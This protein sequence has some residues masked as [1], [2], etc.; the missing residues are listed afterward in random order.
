MI[1]DAGL[2]GRYDTGRRLSPADIGTWMA[3]ARPFLPGPGGAVL[4]LG[5]GT[6]RFGRA[7]ARATGARIVSCEPSA[8]MRAVCPSRPLVGGSAEALPFRGRAFDAIWASQMIHHVG[9]L[10]AFTGNVRRVLRPG[11]RL[12]LRGGFGPPDDLPFY[13]YFPA[14]WPDRTGMS[15]VLAAVDLPRIAHLHVE[16]T[17]AESPREFVE[18]ARSRAL[19]NL[20]ALDDDLFGRGIRAMERDAAEGRLPAPVVE[21]LDLVVFGV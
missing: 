14:A 10:A 20:A 9:D 11:G 12:L 5:A 2:A 15:S 4:D 19:S 17:L 3:A 6:G 7:L 21:R 8:A 18:R 13:R 1:F 16:Q